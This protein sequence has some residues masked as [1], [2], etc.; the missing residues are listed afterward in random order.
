MDAWAEHFVELWQ[1][2]RVAIAEAVLEAVKRNPHMPV[3]GY[4]MEDMQQMFDGTLAMMVEMIKGEEAEIWDTYMNVVIPG[5]IAQGNPLSA[6][7]GQLTMNGVVL[8]QLLVPRARE[9]HRD[10]I[11]E[12]LVNFYSAFNS[13]SVR[14]TYESGA[15][16][17][18]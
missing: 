7:I 18:V 11:S 15:K 12:F 3:K 10:K 14:M 17:S 2:N 4:S 13:E 9:E 6:L 8:H 5:L 1:A 16:A